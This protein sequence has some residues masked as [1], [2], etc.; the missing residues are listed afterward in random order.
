MTKIVNSLV[1]YIALLRELVSF[2]KGWV[3]DHCHDR[4]ICIMT[5]MDS[6]G[7]G[8]PPPPIYICQLLYIYIYNIYTICTLLDLAPP[9]QNFWLR[10]CHNVVSGMP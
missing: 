3:G 7:W 10:Q 9:K 5:Y 4:S 8:E 6:K 2:C 1:G